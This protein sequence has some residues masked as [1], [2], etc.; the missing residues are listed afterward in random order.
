MERLFLERVYRSLKHAAILVMVIPGSP[1]TV[2][3]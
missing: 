1:I 2:W 3:Y